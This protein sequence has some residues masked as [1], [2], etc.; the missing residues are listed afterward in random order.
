MTPKTKNPGGSEKAEGRRARLLKQ[1]RRRMGERAAQ[2]A[3]RP[4]RGRP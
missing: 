2:A 3:P 1:V 4:G